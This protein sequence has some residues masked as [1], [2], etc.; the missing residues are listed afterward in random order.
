[1]TAAPTP[2]SIANQVR[3]RAG[4]RLGVAAVAAALIA[5]VGAGTAGSQQFPGVFTVTTT[6]DGNDG[7]CTDND[8]T[9]REAIAAAQPGGG[10]SI[11][12]PPGVYRLTQGPLVFTQ[13]AV[14]IGPGLIG[15]QGAGARTAIIDARGASRVVQVASGSN[16]I[17]A[18]VT[19]KGG[20]ADVGAGVLVESGGILNLF[21]VAVEDNVA[22]SRGG[23]VAALGGVAISS[24]TISGNRAPSGAGLAVDTDGDGQ[25]A[26]STVSGN[27]ATGS[28]GGIS[29][30]GSM[31]IHGSTVARNT[32]GGYFQESAVGAG[33]TMWNSI[34]S[35]NT[36]GACGGSITG[37]PRGQFNRNLADDATC[38]FA[39]EAEGI[40][41]EPRHG[42]LANNGGP[43]DTH[44]LGAGSPAINAADAQFCFGVDQRSAQYVNGCDIGAFE[45][46]GRPPQ[47]QLPPP[48][49][50]ETVNVGLSRGKVRIK[51]PGSDEFFELK[52]EQQVPV[53]S[54]FDTTKG[55]VNLEAAGAS[56]AW[57]Y[58]GLFRMRQGKGR[59][60]LTTL[61]LTGRLD[62]GRGSASTAQRRRKKRRLWGDGKGRFRTD[63]SFSSA[64]VRGTKW[65]VVDQ[66]NG[67]LTRVRQGRVAVRYGKRT[68][69]LTKGERFFARRR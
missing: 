52:G 23:G 66:C 53:G 9:L 16:S 31:L 33:I 14:V 18:G 13:S 3:S 30:A 34:L 39:S 4:I 22:T 25:L 7:Q 28:G 2:K 41:A 43:T 40:V 15:G 68:I 67:T 58:R 48:V 10:T 57:F 55:R 61:K 29:S 20:A 21:N 32:G 65:L 6:A 35:G 17:I 11:T 5:L 51:L 69:I 49:A 56:R 42:A 26:V 37:L 45:F 1:L 24:S 47:V 44:A 38:A 46:G 50:G 64:T 63:G 62:C 60:P 36:G 54:T 8:C 27:T 19:I 12:L 59:R